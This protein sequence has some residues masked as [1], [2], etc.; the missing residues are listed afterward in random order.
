MRNL[1]R[2]ALCVFLLISVAFGAERN[3]NTN[4]PFVKQPGDRILALQ[5]SNGAFDWIITN[6]TGPTSTTHYNIAGVTGEIFID[7]YRMTNDPI[8]LNAAKKVG[9]Y[10]VGTPISAAQRQN[11][12]NTVF[13][14]HLTDVSSDAQYSTK[15]LQ[16]FTHIKSDSNYWTA[17]N[18]NHCT[19]SG[20]LADQLLEADKDYRGATLVPKGIVVWDLHHFVETAIRSGDNTYALAI[21]NI[22]DAYLSQPGYVD[23]IDYYEFGLSAGISAL[24]LVGG[25]DCSMYVAKLIAKQHPTG[26]FASP[27]YPNEHIQ[28]TAYAMKALK[29]AGD[30]LHASQAANFLRTSFGYT[31]G[32]VSFDG[33]LEDTVEYS[34]VTSEAA[35]ALFNYFY[36]SGTYYATVQG[37]INASS[38]ADTIHVGTGTY[39]E[40]LSITTANLAMIGAGENLV[41]I[42]VAGKTGG[43]LQSGILVTAP[44]VTLRGF[45]LTSDGAAPTASPRYGI[46]FSHTNNGTVRQVT[47]QGLYRSGIDLNTATDMTI[48]H[49]TAQNNGGNGIGCQDV[50]SST[51]SNITTSGNPWGGV[52]TQTYYGTISGVVVSGVNNFQE[53]AASGAGGLYLEQSNINPAGPPYAITYG[54]SGSPDVLLQSADFNYAVRGNDNE[55]PQYSR[56]WFYKT[57]SD[58]QTAAALPSGAPGHI[59]DARFIQSLV[60]NQWYVPSNLGSVPAAISASKSGDTINVMGVYSGKLDIPKDV[61]VRF[62]VPPVLDSVVV[63]G[64]DLVLPSTITISGVLNL[65]NGNVVT[66]DTSKIVFDTTSASPIETSTGKIIGTVEVIP[67]QTGTGPSA[68]VRTRYSSRER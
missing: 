54:L 21:A 19:S 42:N 9:D 25:F 58:A 55:A 33:W 53:S 1:S 18:G 52:R 38:S 66:G 34:E 17:H 57:L 36:V 67:R 12:F 64:G 56:I 43:G 10:I 4:Y 45:T 6:A 44:G 62:A 37:A 35:Q 47:V 14:Y 30:S 48:D 61:T 49:V 23:G 26:Y 15:A 68:V 11:A 40:A 60:D 50:G 63:T 7:A 16:I 51:F 41:T 2:I 3:V 31:S 13:L 20:C 46:K 5:N 29:A 27:N 8:Y 39:N 28:S 32:A 22:I 59:T 65:T 24:K